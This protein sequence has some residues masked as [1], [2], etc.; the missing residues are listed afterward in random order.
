MVALQVLP[1]FTKFCKISKTPYFKGFFDNRAIIK[2]DCK[3]DF[4]R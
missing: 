1:I 3:M 2:A 4:R